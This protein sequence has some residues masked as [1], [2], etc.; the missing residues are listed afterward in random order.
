VK[1]DIEWELASADVEPPRKPT[2]STSAATALDPAM[3]KRLVLQ[4]PTFD[5]LP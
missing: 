3:R 4:Y 2:Q 5:Y 1:T